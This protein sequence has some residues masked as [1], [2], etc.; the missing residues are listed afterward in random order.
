MEDRLSKRTSSPVDVSRFGE[1]LQAEI[2][3]EGEIQTLFDQA[4]TILSTTGAVSSV[5]GSEA[6]VSE[7]FADSTVGRVAYFARVFRFTKRGMEQASLKGEPLFGIAFDEDM[8]TRVTTPNSRTIVFSHFAGHPQITVANGNILEPRVNDPEDYKL[9]K[10]IQQTIAEKAS[11]LA[12]EKA[13]ERKT[14]AKYRHQRMTEKLQKYAR[15]VGGTV[16]AGIVLVGGGKLIS[17]IDIAESYSFDKDP[18]VIVPEGGTVLHIGDRP[19]SPDFVAEFMSD[20]T[21][22]RRN[23]PDVHSG[24]GSVS[25][26]PLKPT[27]VLRDVILTSSEE[28]KNCEHVPLED[29]HLDSQLVAWTD[30][31]GSNGEMRNDQLEVQ[32]SLDVARVCFIGE[33]TSDEDDPRVI[34]Q[35]ITPG[36][37]PELVDQTDR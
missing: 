12:E 17:Q 29:V 25:A 18:E 22:S 14:E 16:V 13:L 11:V 28:G 35:L 21:L 7:T 26:S 4:N 1:A 30:F 15:R 5:N 9:I 19:A 27:H 23:I 10:S 34:L 8:D 33:E 31:V 2:I 6:L 24:S 3:N 36:I 37:E 20:N 32:F